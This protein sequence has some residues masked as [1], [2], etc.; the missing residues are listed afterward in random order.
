MTISLRPAEAREHG[1]RL[2]WWDFL[3]YALF[4][5][6]VPRQLLPLAWLAGS[7]ATVA[8]LLVSFHFDLATGPVIVCACTAAL[9]LA[10]GLRRVT[11]EKKTIEP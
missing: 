4:G 9:L 7:L 8:G 1:W 10:L 3:F 2:G 11:R 6:T 5:V